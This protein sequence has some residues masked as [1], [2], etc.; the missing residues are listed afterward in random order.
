MNTTIT[1]IVTYTGKVWGVKRKKYLKGV[2]SCGNNTVCLSNLRHKIISRLVADKF[3]F[4]DSSTQYV[5]H[6]D[7]DICNNHIDNLEIRN[8][9]LPDIS[10]ILE[11]NKTLNQ[12]QIAKLYGVSR[13]AVN[14]MI[15]KN[16]TVISGE[17]P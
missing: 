7:G 11:L 15:L 14:N 9:K 4:T 6:K 5:V 17:L 13:Q 3:L 10:V 12:N 16:K 8:Y 1:H 2:V